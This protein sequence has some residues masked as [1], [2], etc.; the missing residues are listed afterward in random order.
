MA[1]VK[2]FLWYFIIIYMLISVL[3][4]FNKYSLVEYFF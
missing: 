4:H 2:S 3:A 1:I